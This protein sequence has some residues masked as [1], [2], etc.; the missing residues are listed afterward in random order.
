[1]NRLIYFLIGIF[2]FFILLFFSLAIHP[3]EVPDEQSHYATVHYL[4]NEG[5]MPILSKHADLSLEEEKTEYLLGVMSEG[6]NQYSH[7]PQFRLSPAAGVIGLYEKEIRS[8]NTAPLRRTYTIHQAAIYPPLYYYLT[9]PF[10]SLA[11]SSDILSR[12]FSSRLSSVLLSTAMILFAYWFGHVVFA[13]KKLALILAIMTL[14]FPMTSY[15]GAGVNSDNLHNLLFTIFLGLCVRLIKS[16]L[17]TRFTVLTALVI[18]LD[19][20][21]KPQA[22]IMLP[23]FALAI[24]LRGN[25]GDWRRSIRELIY[26]TLTIVVV[27][28]WL[29][30]P[31][32][33]DTGT[34]MIAQSVLYGGWSNF[35]TF[36]RHYFTLAGP[37]LVWYWGVFKWFGVVLPHPV[38]WVANRLVLLS[39][40]GII[41]S[42]VGDWRQHRF[43]LA[44]KIVIFSLLANVGYLAALLWFDWQFYEQIGRSLGLQARYFLPLLITQMFL[45]L[46]GLSHL[47]RSPQVKKYLWWGIMI[48]FLTLH[49]AGLYTQLTSY[50]DLTTLRTFINQISQYKPIYAKGNWWYLWFSLYFTGIIG[51]CS[52]AFSSSSQ[53][54]TKPKSSSLPSKI[55][56]HT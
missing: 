36:T 54:T 8:L 43:S 11:G 29:H 56:K 53:P 32:Y 9:I 4:V 42:F 47:S 13:E 23:I 18:G 22:Y 30:Q 10:Y 41:I 14:F 5:T 2:S 27:A 45:L 35:L 19:I 16:G 34:G 50:Y 28:G 40:V 44:N 52:L 20:L 26:F 25:F 12:L 48:F 3:F 17:D 7:H 55:S 38:W 1:M 33:L 15:V 51:L 6:N 46:S 49:L 37:M 21:T 24:I 39:L 31:Q